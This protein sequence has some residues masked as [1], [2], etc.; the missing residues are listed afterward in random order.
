MHP[1]LTTFGFRLQ[2][3]QEQQRRHREYQKLLE[4]ARC[5]NWDF[6]K[7]AKTPNAAKIPQELEGHKDREKWGPVL[8]TFLAN[9]YNCED[10]EAQQ[11]HELA[12]QIQQNTHTTTRPALT[13]HPNDLRD[14]LKQLPN[15][16]AAGKDGIPS[17]VLKELPFRHIIKL[18]TLFQQLAND[19]QFRSEHRPLIWEEA[20]VPMLPKEA[21]ATSLSKYRPIS[22][23]TQVQKLYTKWILSQCSTALDKQIDEHQS[24]IRRQR[25]AAETLYTIQRVIEIHL[26]W[27]HPLTI[28]KV[29]LQKAFDSIYQSTILQGLLH[30]DTHPVLIFNL[31]RE[32][33][34][35]RITPQIWGCIPAQDVQLKRGSK[36][37]APESGT[38]FILAINHLLKPLREK[39]TLDK[40]GFPL[41]PHTLSHLIFVDDLILIGRTPEEV[42]HMFTSVET[43]LAQGGLKI[44]K[45][46]TAY[47]TSLP[48]RAEKCLP[49]KN[50]NKNGIPI[51]GRH[52]T[53]NDNTD[54]EIQRREQVAW[55]K[56]HKLKHILRAPTSI[57]H[58]IHIFNACI[59]QSL[60]W[61][62]HTWHVTK[63]RPQ[64][65]RLRGLERKM[66]RT[67][68]PLPK[69]LW[70]LPA[71]QRFQLHNRLI[72][73]TIKEIHHEPLDQKWLRRWT[74][75]MGHLARL[76]PPTLGQNLS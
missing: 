15:H 27:A 11:I 76:P 66:L 47:M 61:A 32:L 64:H 43:A 36:Q 28:L 20:I 53:L 38:L 9:L 41:H 65:L 69:H 31:C 57:H 29:D 14:I 1:L 62:S 10:Q 40:T 22:L 55:S 25:Q 46:K 72:N 54:R 30:T 3:H 21:G 49:G 74:A 35:N 6:A 33:L 73:R 59:L 12:W 48:Q 17:Q 13:C 4:Q 45:D 44:N 50:Q 58:R 7:P 60:L 51:L 19:N 23:M 37:G 5:Q 26:E 63:K 56:F 42:S 39:W 52:F 75:W 71:D 8:G 18:A 16:R 68:I 24:G 70:D 2:E 34:G 67:L